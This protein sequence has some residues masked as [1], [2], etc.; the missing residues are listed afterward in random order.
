MDRNEVSIAFELLSKE[1]ESVLESLNQQGA[2]V[3]RKRDYE[4]AIQ[5]IEDATRITDLRERILQ[6][7][8]QNLFAS[9]VAREAPCRIKR[10]YKN[11]NVACGLQKTHSV[12]QFLRLW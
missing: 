8:W 4:A 9:K 11:S 3:L 10:A 5:L 2:S 6:K 12:N 7:E 1:I